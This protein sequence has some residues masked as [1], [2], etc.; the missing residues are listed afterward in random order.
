MLV[1]LADVAQHLVHNVMKLRQHTLLY[2]SRIHNIEKSA[3][4]CTSLNKLVC[5]PGAL[6][7]AELLELLSVAVAITKIRYAKLS[8]AVLTVTS[9]LTSFAK[10][11]AAW[12]QL[13]SLFFDEWQQ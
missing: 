13:N 9:F 2:V 3:Q 8:G 10:G 12:K 11:H 1:H 4:V 6:H 7:A 5:R